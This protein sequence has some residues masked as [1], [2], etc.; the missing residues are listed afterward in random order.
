MWSQSVAFPGLLFYCLIHYMT[1]SKQLLKL[2]IYIYNIKRKKYPCVVKAGLGDRN[3]Y[4]SGK[5]GDKP[6][7][8]HKPDKR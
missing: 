3:L 8:R 4:I 2:F 1:S 7:K 5:D 6:N